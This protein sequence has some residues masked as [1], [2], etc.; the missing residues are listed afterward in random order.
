MGI[1]GITTQ[2]TWFGDKEAMKLRALMSNLMDE[3]EVHEPF[4]TSIEDRGNIEFYGYEILWFVLSGL[5]Y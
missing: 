2:S 5:S 1:I 4:K 3:A